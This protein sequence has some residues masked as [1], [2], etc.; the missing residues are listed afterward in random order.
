MTAYY[1]VNIAIISLLC[2]WLMYEH[3]DFRIARRY[4][5]RKF[6]TKY[7]SDVLYFLVTAKTTTRHINQV[8]TADWQKK[9]P[10]QLEWCYPEVKQ[11]ES[12]GEAEYRIRPGRW[13]SWREYEERVKSFLFL[14]DIAQEEKK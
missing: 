1:V 7:F 9:L 8:R 5:Y 4:C 13:V 6:G 11:R 3:N 10:S 2:V 12:F 14:Y